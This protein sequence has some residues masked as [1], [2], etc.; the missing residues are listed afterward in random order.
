MSYRWKE[1]IMGKNDREAINNGAALIGGLLVGGLVVGGHLV[2]GLV[3]LVCCVV[4]IAV[5]HYL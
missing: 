3:M 4:G 5:E 2:A 1:K